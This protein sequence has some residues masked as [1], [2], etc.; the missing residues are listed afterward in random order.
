MGDSFC[1]YFL[2]A[3]RCE[4]STYKECD[5]KKYCIGNCETDGWRDG[6]ESS[7]YNLLRSARDASTRGYNWMETKTG[8]NYPKGENGCF[9]NTPST[10]RDLHFNLAKWGY[11][12][13][14]ACKNRKSK[15]KYN[16]DCILE[17]NAFNSIVL[18]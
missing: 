9:V 17:A 5:D 3:D 2:L 1:F 6:E 11:S 12:P 10:C 15:Y 13:S 8:R 7:S 14:Q 18:L 16:I 4:C